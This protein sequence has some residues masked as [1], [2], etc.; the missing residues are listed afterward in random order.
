VYR[1]FQN[2]LSR[3][4]AVKAVFRDRF[5]RLF[6]QER[7]RQEAEVVANLIHPNIITIYE[8]GEK[9]EFMY[10]V[11]Q[12]V[13]GISLSQWLKQ[14][15][16]HPLPRKRVPELSELVGICEQTLEVLVYAH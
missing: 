5:N 12:L 2:T 15:K 10:F 11:M 6:T 1:G 13:D 14:K 16:R 3:P 8:F 9:P 4:V 7:F